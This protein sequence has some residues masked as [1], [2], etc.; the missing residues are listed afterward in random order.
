MKKSRNILLKQVF[1]KFLTETLSPLSSNNLLD[2]VPEKNKEKI[3]KFSQLLTKSI[4]QNSSDEFDT[5]INEKNL[6]EKLDKL[7]DIIQNNFGFQVDMTA[8]SFNPQ[9]PEQ[10]KRNIVNITKKEEIN[11]LKNIIYSLELENNN[12]KEIE[13]NSRNSLQDNI[14]KIEEIHQFLD[15]IE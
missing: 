7:D 9:D 10:I 13:F 2:I 5:I 6:P 15:K 1:N 12:L 8:F 14:E 11:R 4:I 3:I